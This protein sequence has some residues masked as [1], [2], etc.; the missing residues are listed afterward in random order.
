MKKR[1][2]TVLLLLNMLSMAAQVA[3]GTTTPDSSSALEIE[4]TTGAL[5]PPRMTSAQMNA[6]TPLEGAVV[7]NISE[8]A[9]YIYT[10]ANWVPINGSPSIVL[11]RQGGTIQTGHNQFYNFPLNENHVLVDDDNVYTV[12]GN[13]SIR[14]NKSGTY[15]FNAAFSSSNVPNGAKKYIILVRRNGANI[16]YLTRGIVEISNQPQFWGTSGSLMYPINA[17]DVIDFQYVFNNG[18]SPLNAV[19]FNCSIS[20]IF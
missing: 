6:L 10:D 4:S 17:N 3:I 9:M 13:G 5:V 15:F 18:G 11:N 7:F 2:L 12:L 8:N 16:G 14:V 19:F 20:K 1:I